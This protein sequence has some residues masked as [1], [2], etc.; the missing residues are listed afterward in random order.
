MLPIYYLS[1]WTD[2]WGHVTRWGWICSRHRVIWVWQKLYRIR[3]KRL[4]T[5][6]TGCSTLALLR[7]LVLFVWVQKFQCEVGL[8][9][10][11]F[12]EFKTRSD[13]SR[14]FCD[15]FVTCC[16]QN[17]SKLI[18]LHQN[19]L[20]RKVS[21]HNGLCRNVMSFS[22]LWNTLKLVRGSS[23]CTAIF[24]GLQFLR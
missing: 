20:R 18:K 8:V 17:G 24:T 3:H 2:L 14:F 5:S 4:S 1:N 19:I 10:N 16:G 22:G 9:V 7:M 13:S 12:L 23:P 6:A 15:Q 21:Q 11:Q